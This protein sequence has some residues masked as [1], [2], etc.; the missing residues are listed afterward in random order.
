MFF[1]NSYMKQQMFLL[2]FAEHQ[3]LLLWWGGGVEYIV[4][5]LN[6]LHGYF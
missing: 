3:F 5:F 6:I 1:V 2:S 4:T